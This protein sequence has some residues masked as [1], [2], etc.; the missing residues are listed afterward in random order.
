MRRRK[1]TNLYGSRQYKGGKAQPKEDQGCE[2]ERAGLLIVKFA[3]CAAVRFLFRLVS[4][5]RE[6]PELGTPRAFPF[7]PTDFGNRRR[8][9][10]FGAFNFFL[11]FS[12]QDCARRKTIE[13]LGALLLAFDPN[14]RG[15]MVKHNTRRN[16]IN[17]LATGSRRANELFFDV[18]FSHS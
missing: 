2:G 7:L 17:I 10:R 11:D 15:P 16:L 13:S 9:S 1:L 18:L 6:Q 12:K 5:V 4:L 14:P 3:H 8:F